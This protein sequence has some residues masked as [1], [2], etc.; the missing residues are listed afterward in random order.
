MKYRI[1]EI[2]QII[3]GG[4][5]KT[6]VAEYWNGDICWLSVKDFAGDC[7]YVYDTE[8][9]NSHQRIYANAIL[10]RRLAYDKDAI[11]MFCN[12]VGDL[13]KLENKAIQESTRLSTL[14]DTLL[15]KLMSGQIKV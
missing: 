14:R 15:P 12:L 4:T 8:K 13:L 9:K 10:S 5:P 7:R 1:P 6:S 2:C 3:G 11:A